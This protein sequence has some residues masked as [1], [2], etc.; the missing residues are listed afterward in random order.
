MTVANFSDR[1]TKKS[2]LCTGVL[3]KTPEYFFPFA[4]TTVRR[5]I[6]FHK[7]HL[8]TRLWARRLSKREVHHIF[9]GTP[10]LSD[11]GKKE[12]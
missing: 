10:S 4:Q 8:T 11:S 2:V 1:Y 9:L 3:L 12:S 5:I 6:T 7:G